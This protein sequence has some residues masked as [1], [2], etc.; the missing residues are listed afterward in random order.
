[1]SL[2]PPPGTPLPPPP[3]PAQACYRHPDRL[4]GRSC[5]RCGKP[6][7]ADCLQPASVGSLCPDC[8][9]AGKA[10]VGTRIRFFQAGQHDLVTKAL[11]AIN[12]AV[13][14][15]AIAVGGG[16]LLG[17]S[18]GGGTWYARFALISR[19][20]PSAGDWYR[21]VAEGGLWRLIT[22]GFMH[23]GI[24]HIALNMY[25]LFV[26]GP[27]L[28][29]EL[30]RSRFLM[31]YVAALL[32][33]SAGA[34]IVTPNAATVGASGAIFGLFGAFA[35]GLYQRGVNPFRTGIG[36]TL[37]INLALTFGLPGISVGGH[38]GGLIGGAVCGW[39]LLGHPTRRMPSWT[40]AVPAAVGGVA[41]AVALVAANRV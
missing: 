21:G 36:T 8:M 7:C 9:R 2:S 16:K 28:E 40:Y 5:T 1:M 31:V 14:L 4:T 23:D 13:F 39:F 27:S 35:T 38:I 29:R 15:G 20:A 11:V 34:L 26:I 3:P 30:G 22:S 17:G 12:L 10:S 24:I 32:A 33:G 6:A 37:L 18:S 19:L 25:V 41:V